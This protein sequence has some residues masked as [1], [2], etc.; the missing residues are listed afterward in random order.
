LEIRRKRMKTSNL[1]V[2]VLCTILVLVASPSSWATIK[3]EEVEKGIK[4]GATVMH[5]CTPSADGQHRDYCV[6]TT[7]DISQI[8]PPVKSGET[9]SFDE[10]FYDD[11]GDEENG[12]WT[13]N[14]GRFAWDGTLQIEQYFPI[15]CKNFRNDIDGIPL[16][17]EVC[18]I[19]GARLR[20]NYTPGPSD[21]VANVSDVQ[22]IQRFVVTGSGCGVQP[23]FDEIDTAGNPI[24]PFYPDWG[25]TKDAAGNDV[26]KIYQDT[27]ESGCALPPTNS[28]C[29]HSRCSTRG[30][31]W[32]E[33]IYT[34]L[35]DK[36]P[37][38]L[39]D[40]RIHDGIFWQIHSECVP[41]PNPKKGAPE[42]RAGSGSA[43]SYDPV[44]KILSFGDALV[45]SLN[46]DGSGQMDPAFANDPILGA[47][48]SISDFELLVGGDG[49]YV[50][51]GGKYTISKNDIVFFEASI[52][53]MLIDDE[54]QSLFSDNIYGVFEDP[55]FDLT[56][57]SQWLA[58]YQ[59][60]W[61]SDFVG[62]FRASTAMPIESYLEQGLAFNTS[63]AVRAA[64]CVPEP[65][66]VLLLG[67]GG[68][69]LLRRRR[70]SK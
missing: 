19:H 22:F 16:Y 51:T 38:P 15:V 32:V 7:S 12:G 33:T 23:P 58:D 21:S 64:Y 20:M 24:S 8:G 2:I 70:C 48:V 13:I 46:L 45:E 39:N 61:D 68:L 29:A 25:C 67:L 53:T 3:L 10:V 35:A 42:E 54:G 50:F 49:A 52:P 66:T 62:E 28:D 11:Y 40:V 5:C 63:A 26:A 6:T 56:Q 34:Y 18:C 27:P 1:K 36:T 60:L 37:G 31:D 17:A 14:D 30:C 59:Q 9:G 69:A 47:T 55:I 41:G 44:S 43:V 65:A 57:G 4:N